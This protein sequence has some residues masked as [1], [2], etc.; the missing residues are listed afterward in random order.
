MILPH[1]S[2]ASACILHARRARS[3]AAAIPFLPP[4]RAP[5][6]DRPPL[7]LRCLRGALRCL[8][9]HGVDGDD[10]L[11][12]PKNNTTLTRAARLRCY[13]YN[14][15]TRCA[16]HTAASRT[17][18]GIAR[19]RI[20][21][22]RYCCLFGNGCSLFRHTVAPYWRS[23]TCPYAAGVVATGGPTNLPSFFRRGS[24]PACRTRCCALPRYSS[25]RLMVDICLRVL[26]IPLLTFTGRYTAT[27]TYDIT[28]RALQP[29]TS[30]GRHAVLRITTACHT[31]LFGSAARTDTRR[32]P[33]FFPLMLFSTVSYGLLTS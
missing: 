25:G 15:P 13:L 32:A 19:A 7:P 16:R 22:A 11:F 6:P 31:R 10:S 3:S 4:L 5:L 26:R 28:Y 27:D 33:R 14:K 8:P 12:L 30:G 24:S 20:Q 17:H 9:H 29:A 2:R 1:L 18:T 23:Y 21:N